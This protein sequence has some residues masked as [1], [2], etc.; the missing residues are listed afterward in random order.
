MIS[1]PI[2]LPLKEAVAETKKQWITARR[3]NR[4]LT[5]LAKELGVSTRTIIRWERKQY[6]GA[7][8]KLYCHF[9]GTNEK[10]H[11][12]HVNGKENSAEVIP[13]CE[14]CHIRFHILNRK[15]KP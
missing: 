11:G 4:R 3:R 10:I 13:L 9:C 15:L 12:H 8:R 5:D 14:Q 7:K 1:V 6:R 2:E